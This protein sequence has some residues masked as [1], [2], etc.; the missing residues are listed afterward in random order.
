MLVTLAIVALLVLW[1]LG[2]VVFQWGAIT[3]ILL[4][5]ALILA[6]RRLLQERKAKYEAKSIGRE[7]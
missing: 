7:L 4:V 1:L 3:H 6:I 5:A 2:F